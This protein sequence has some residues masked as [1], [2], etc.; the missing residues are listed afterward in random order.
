MTIRRDFET[1]E[2]AGALRR[3]V[4]GRG[5]I[6][7]P[8]THEP[9]LMTRALERSATKAHLARAA[10]DLIKADEVV[11]FDGGSTALAI[12]RELQRREVPLTVLTRS[13]L[14]A[15]E[16]SQASNVDIYLLGGKVK[17]AEMLTTG[18]AA[19]DDLVSYNVD[20]YIMGISGVHPTRGLTDY[21]PDE[22]AGK[23]VAI[24]MADRVVLTFDH[25]KLNRVLL[26]RVATLADVDIVVTDAPPG[27]EVLTTLP[28]D[29][30][31]VL[32]D[33]E[34]EALEAS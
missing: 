34:P 26:S 6:L 20:T 29:L 2:D 11:Y 4:G 7:E 17:T 25:S 31:L 19:N 15:V 24:A 28:P 1:L 32:V 14:V 12:A 33:P 21:D 27:H 23:R 18:P 16:F 3:L 13:L 8:K 22:A 30:T 9:A 10:A 5:I